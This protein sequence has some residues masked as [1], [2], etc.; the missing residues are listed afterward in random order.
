MNTEKTIKEDSGQFQLKDSGYHASDAE[1]DKMAKEWVELLI[2]HLMC[3]IK[4]NRDT[5]CS[6]LSLSE[7]E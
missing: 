5:K 1:I 4:N 6:P 7:K 2:A 3:P